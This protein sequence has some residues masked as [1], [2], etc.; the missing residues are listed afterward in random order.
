MQTA[1]FPLLK[2]YR[3]KISFPQSK[4][5]TLGHF[6][7]FFSISKTLRL[8]APLLLLINNHDSLSAQNGSDDGWILKRNKGD[9]TIYMREIENSPI[10]DL[11]FEM[12][13]ESSLNSL[14]ALLL[15]VDGFNDWVYASV[16]SET[17][18]KI[19]NTEVVYYN[20]IDFPWPLYNRDLVLQTSLWQD[21]KTL[22]LHSKTYSVH[23]ELPEKEGMVRMKRA[24]IHWQF[25]PIGNGMVKLHYTLSS[26]PGG[27]IPAWMINFAADQGP[28]LTMDK[29]LEILAK[30]K[31]QKAVVPYIKELE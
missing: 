22:T 14:A 27:S 11:K 4:A 28:L 23:D 31:Y 16:V 7:F 24:D 18:R 20:E 13:F 21:D 3:T 8:L 15:D 1:P 19:S 10:K 5:K 17:V 29:F 9:I 6:P 12:E 25:T 26:D 2:M 30:E